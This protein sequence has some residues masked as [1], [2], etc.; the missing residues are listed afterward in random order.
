[1]S[2]LLFPAT[3]VN[4]EDP[5]MLGRIRAYPLDQNIESVLKGYN[6][7]E[8]KDEFTEKDP[9]VV[10]PLLPMFLSQVPLVNERVSVILQNSDRRYQD[11]YYVQGAYSSPM[12]F[13][14]ENAQAANKD[15]SLGYRIKQ[16]LALKNNNGQL[17]K[18]TT[19]FGVFPELDDVSV[20][21]RGTSDIIVK[22]KSVLIRA[23]KTFD[24]KVNKFPVANEKKAFIQVSSFDSR[25]VPGKSQDLLTFNTLNK[26]VNYLIEWN[27]YNLENTQNSFTGDVILYK[28]KQ[29]EATTTDKISYNSD[30][31]DLRFLVFNQPF[32]ALTIENA[33]QFI[34]VFINR[35][36]GGFFPNGATLGNERFPF[37]YRP[38]Q[39][40][41]ELLQPGNPDIG[42]PVIFSNAAKFIGGITL[43][44][45]TGPNSYNFGLVSSNGTIG[46]PSE[47]QVETI[48]PKQ[49]E[50]AFGTFMMSAADTLV[51]MSHK[52]GN[53]TFDPKLSPNPNTMM[54]ISQQQL[55][56]N[57]IPN[58]YAMI[59]GDIL[60]DY[61]EKIS[62]FLQNHVHPHANLPPSSLTWAGDKKSDLFSFPWRFRALNENIRI[63]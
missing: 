40:I 19:T 4:N 47:V 52:T 16:N 45:G 37:V 41:R 7:Q 54:G 30:L 43:N 26:Q 14:F 29:N 20:L 21:G 32:Q 49:V 25:I 10:L 56:E 51:M 62:S 3:V 23:G 46:K 1:M 63:N 38:S 33:I 39:T 57:V 48:T 61:L 6:F 31:T 15:T 22:E 44:A 2:K 27:V 28:L 36:N 34:N 35:I 12:T 55:E 13:P 50:S 8:G 5:M 17:K 18:P 59:R 24:L 58:T 60:F 42:D 11:A 53:I 9:F